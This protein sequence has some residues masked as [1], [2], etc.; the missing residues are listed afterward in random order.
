[1]AYYLTQYFIRSADLYDHAIRRRSDLH[2]LKPKRNI[3]KI[4]FKYMEGQFISVFYP[5]VLKVPLL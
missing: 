1:M 5:I 3:G 2:P 4:I